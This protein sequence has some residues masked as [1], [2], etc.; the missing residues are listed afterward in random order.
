[1]K[2]KSAGPAR[3]SLQSLEAGVT[4]RFSPGL[5]VGDGPTAPMGNRS[6][7]TPPHAARPDLG[8]T[9]AIMA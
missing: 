5:H 2:T 9:V 4:G 6:S 3:A 8:D 1:M 7:S